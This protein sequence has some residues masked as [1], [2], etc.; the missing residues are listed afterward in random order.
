MTDVPACKR[1]VFQMLSESTARAD[2]SNPI[3]AVGIFHQQRSIGFYS[4][5]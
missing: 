5:K 3:K 1:A 4:P 2:G